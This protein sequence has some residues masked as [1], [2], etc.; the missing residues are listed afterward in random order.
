MS[1]VAPEIDPQPPPDC[2]AALP[3]V[4]ERLR[5][6]RS[7]CRFDAVSGR[8]PIRPLD[9]LIVG[10]VRTPNRGPIPADVPV[11]AGE[12]DVTTPPS[13]PI[14]ARLPACESAICAPVGDA[15][16]PCVGGRL[17]RQP[18]LGPAARRHLVDL[19]DAVAGR[20]SKA[21]IWPS[22]D[23]LGVSSLLPLLVSFVWLPRRARSSRRCRSCRRGWWRRRCPRRPATR[24]GRRSAGSAPTEFV[25]CVLPGAVVP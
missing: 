17:V 11:T 16:R 24:R 5:A 21:I 18:H 4:R 2:V 3:L 23:Q 9:G 6:R 20:T 15:R 1:A 22:G 12:N 13:A 19:V 7:R 25:S 8:P 10:G 14:V